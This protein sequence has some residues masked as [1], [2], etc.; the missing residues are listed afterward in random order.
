MQWMTSAFTSSLNQARK[1]SPM[2]SFENGKKDVSRAQSQVL[3][4]NNKGNQDLAFDRAQWRKNE[5]YDPLKVLSKQKSKMNTL[6]REV[7]TKDAPDKS[8]FI[9]YDYL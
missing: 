1:A 2:R 4:P 7:S 8:V 5:E 9:R 6:L 3:S